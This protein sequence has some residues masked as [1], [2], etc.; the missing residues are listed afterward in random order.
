MTSIVSICNLALSSLG[1]DNISALTEATAEARASNQFYQ[2]T[3]DSLL[4]SYPWLFAGKTAALGQIA[5]GSMGRWS[6]VYS[7]PNDC[8]K[9][10]WVRPQYSVTDH[11]PLSLHE[12]VNIPY[13]VEGDSIYCNISPAFLRYTRRVDDPTKFPPLF[14]EALSFALA[15][16]MAMP[17]TRDPKTRGEMYQAA[18]Q[19]RA[20][21][22][23][24]DANEQ[25]ET[26]DHNSEL[27]AVR[28]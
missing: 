17:L 20:Q 26:S 14:V 13:E 23:V 6:Y 4:Q 19:V 9:V 7:R 3:L 2:Q 5:N 16:R 27:V 12:E 21:A 22:E 10:R 24:A 11:L 1:K 18:A 15:A 8:L 25:R 28:H